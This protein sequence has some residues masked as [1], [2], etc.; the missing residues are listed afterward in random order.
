MDNFFNK[1]A[2]RHLK[3]RLEVNLGKC[4]GCAACV[5]VCPTK[6]IGMFPWIPNVE[7]PPKTGEPRLRPEINHQDCDLCCR[8]QKKCPRSAIEVYRSWLAKLV[9]KSSFS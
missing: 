4:I 2:S 8:C 3:A 7:L 9:D 5:S 1:F 6:A